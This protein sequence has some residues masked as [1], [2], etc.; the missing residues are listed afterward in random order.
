MSGDPA[1][2]QASFTTLNFS[3]SKRQHTVLASLSGAEPMVLKMGYP[4]GEQFEREK[5]FY[6]A[7]PPFPFVPEASLV[8]GCTLALPF[9]PM[10]TL[11]HYADALAAE[12][13]RDAAGALWRIAGLFLRD[14]AAFVAPADLVPSASELERMVKTLGN[15]LRSGPMGTRRS[16]AADALAR[17][18]WRLVMPAFRAALAADFVHPE[19][20]RQAWCHGD[21]HLNNILVDERGARLVWIDW[22][23]SYRGLPWRDLM[24]STAMLA[25]LLEELSP[26]SAE[27]FHRRVAREVLGGRA[28]AAA[29]YA[30]WAPL[31][32]LCAAA[33]SRFTLGGRGLRALR[34][35][36]QVVR[37]SR[38]LAR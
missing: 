24:Y 38:S 8:N 26:G 19:P 31:Y 32:T 30:R 7:R 12:P 10:P 29:I 33:N 9:F 20:A 22:G 15:L 28:A 6:L 18:A 13:G 21:L 2:R 35:L 1:V 17:R 3:T 27:R 34:H 4:G 23:T 25:A 14:L 37:R 11:R 16:R 5:A 36:L